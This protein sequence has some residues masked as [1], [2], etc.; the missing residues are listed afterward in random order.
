MNQ[1]RLFQ[2]LG[3]L[4][5]MG[6]ASRALLRK[7]DIWGRNGPPPHISNDMP[8]IVSALQPLNL[9]VSSGFQNISQDNEEWQ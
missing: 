3:S 9:M 2:S 5:D 4:Q 1:G 6:R 8:A 7:G